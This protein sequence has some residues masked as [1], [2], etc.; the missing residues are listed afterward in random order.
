MPSVEPWRDPPDPAFVIPW[1]TGPDP[2]LDG[3]FR[4]LALRPG[5]Q[6]WLTFECWSRPFEGEKA[7]ARMTREFG[8][9]AADL[10]QAVDPLQA[11]SELDIFL[12]DA[13]VITPDGEGFEA[14]AGALSG[15]P[16]LALGI[17]ELAALW[18]PGRLARRGAGLVRALGEG[19][20]GPPKALYPS[21]LVQA[22]AELLRRAQDRPLE[23]HALLA[24]GYAAAHRELL[25]SDPPAAERLALALALFEH[26]S[27]WAR[28]TGELFHPGEDLP[29]GLLQA[30]LEATGGEV[31]LE[32]L[33]SKAAE[34]FALWEEFVPLQP[35]PTPTEGLSPSDRALL[36]EVFEE[37]LPRILAHRR[38]GSPEEYRRP[39]QAQVAREVAATL[40][41]RE[42]LLVHAPTGTGKTLAYL[43]PGLLWALRNEARLGIATYTR[44]LQEQAM[45]G[46]AEVALAALARAGVA[47]PLR[48]SLL[49][50]R[51]NYLCMRALSLAHPEGGD[52]A[53][54]WLVWT[55]LALFALTD[56]ESDL[57]RLPKDPPLRLTSGTHYRRSLQRILAAVRARTG[58]CSHAEDRARCGAHLARR[59]AERSHVVLTNQSFLLSRPEFFHHVIFDECEHLHDVAAATWSHALRPARLE[60]LLERLAGGKRSP[61]ERL[62]VQLPRGTFAQEEAQEAEKRTDQTRQALDELLRQLHL[63][64]RWRGRRRCPDSER[65]TLLRLYVE[66]EEGEQLVAARLDLGLALGRLDRALGRL[67]EAAGAI[68]LRG[69]ARLLR[70]LELAGVELAEFATDLDAWLPVDG[71]RPKLSPAILHDV[72]LDRHGGMSLTASVLFPGRILR[73]RVYPVLGSVVFLSATTMLGGSFEAA[74]AYLG[75]EESG[76][77]EDEL[78]QLEREVRTAQ[79]PEAFDYGRVLVGLPRDAPPPTRKADHLAY[80]EH[81]LDWLGERTRG[82]I[83]VLFTNK[84]DVRRVGE[85]LRQRFRKRRIP[86]WYQGMAGVSKE[87]LGALFRERSDSILLG[88]DT[89]WFGADF[90]GETLEYLVIPRL[91]FGVPDRLHHAQAAAMG[92][93]IHRRSVYMPRA[94]AKF[95]QGFG[96]LMRRPTDRGVIFILD[97]R[98]GEP[99][100]RPF[101]EELPLAGMH[102]EEGKARLVRGETSRVLHEALAHMGMLADLERRGLTSTFDEESAS[103]SGPADLDIPTEDLPF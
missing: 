37:H 68:P 63:F 4:L 7:S 99:L 75:L 76:E 56:N 48:L 65:H 49:K 25:A 45:D 79:A 82:R 42:L 67:G 46:E 6:G 83:L 20:D 55:Q 53:E 35:S 59:R 9:T 64:E 10:T 73:E 38:G 1:V 17:D 22:L 27:S 3:L 96:R 84:D 32:G 29:A 21:E 23:A 36:E 31:D 58:C 51:E 92:K 88:V 57:N 93:R 13:P 54:A 97:R 43:I 16:R 72:R 5:P 12:G 14:W 70:S 86:L 81:F 80:V 85:A 87:E 60:A 44:A 11:W 39:A 26:P 62:T 33:P 77:D 102:P 24:G 101:L 90:P 74:R 94:L 15:R 18:L 28:S 19:H 103:P 8:V 30:A 91:P 78:P 98:L 50:G 2:E 71:E 34:L 47:G 41:S 95:R 89:F 61:L 100:G 40:G 69:G 52:D 66:G